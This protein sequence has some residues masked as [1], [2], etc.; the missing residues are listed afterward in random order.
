MK[1]ME[2]TLD[3]SWAYL[4]LE[5][6]LAWGGQRICYIGT[7]DMMSGTIQRTGRMRGR[8]KV[9]ASGKYDLVLS[10]NRRL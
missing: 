3:D 9:Y 4:K 10:P 8:R 6:G 5:G 1:N 7:L 2:K